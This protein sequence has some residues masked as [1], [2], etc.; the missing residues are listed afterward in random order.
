M[1]ALALLGFLWMAFPKVNLGIVPDT[2][3]GQLHVIRSFQRALTWYPLALKV[4]V[5]YQMDSQHMVIAYDRRRGRFTWVPESIIGD[6][7]FHWGNSPYSRAGRELREYYLRESMSRIIEN[8]PHA[9]FGE[10]PSA[11]AYYQ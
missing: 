7:N 8:K 11:S 4:T 9:P 5:R 10:M 6:P 2:H 1:I 3:E